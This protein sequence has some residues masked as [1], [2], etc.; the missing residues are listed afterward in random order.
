MHIAG[1][2]TWIRAYLAEPW[3]FRKITETA[4]LVLAATFVIFIL[5]IDW[6]G[7]F[8]KIPGRFA[9]AWTSHWITSLVS[10]MAGCVGVIGCW[11][12]WPKVAVASGNDL[13]LDLLILVTAGL[14]AA[15]GVAVTLGFLLTLLLSPFGDDPP[16]KPQG[17][18][19]LEKEK[20]YGD[21]RAATSLEVDAV[22]RGG[23]SA[24]QREFED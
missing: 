4:A 14:T 7:W 17:P 10:L 22:L 23:P 15:Y 11:Y 21:A 16:L 18:G 24:A 2:Q 8:R 6:R 1:M 13:G 9:F 5:S 20:A 3:S 12:L 19:V